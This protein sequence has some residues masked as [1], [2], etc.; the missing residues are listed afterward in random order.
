MI[1]INALA[2]SSAGNCY[3]VTDGKTPLLI[4]AGIPFREIQRAL[5][6]TV[7]DL[8]GALISHE[9]GD[10]SK[11]AADLMKAGVDIYASRGTI[12]A[13]GLSGHRFRAVLPRLQFNIYSWTI[14]PFEVEHDAAEPLG[15]LLANKSGD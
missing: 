5:N 14:L 15:F 1:E 10:H 13:L 6:Y 11:A 12:D 8:A 7:T 3:R 9:H 2:S 4:E